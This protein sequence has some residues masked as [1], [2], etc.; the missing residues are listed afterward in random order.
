MYIADYVHYYL[1]VFLKVLVSIAKIVT[2]IYLN[3]LT[4]DPKHDLA[5][6]DVQILSLKLFFKR[7]KRKEFTHVGLLQ[8]A[9][10]NL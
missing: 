6:P 5:V 4:H 1:V 9:D 3:N 2:T 8:F 10:D 7:S